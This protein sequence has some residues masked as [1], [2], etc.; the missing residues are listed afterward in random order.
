[1]ES[2]AAQSLFQSR[3]RQ[4]L[5]DEWSILDKVDL[6]LEQAIQKAGGTDVKIDRRRLK[7]IIDGD[8]VRLSFAELQALDT[9]LTRKQRGGLKALFENTTIL[10]VFAKKEKVTF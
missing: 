7:S 4:I 6:R 2:N 3:L 9:F 10:E 5:E 8:D 1:M